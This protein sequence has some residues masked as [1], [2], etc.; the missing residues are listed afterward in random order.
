ML[1]YER[2]THH[3]ITVPPDM[4]IEDALRLMRSEKVRR[5]PVVDQ[6]TK[7]VIGIVTEKD[8]LY[9]SPSPVTS[10]SIHEIHYLL[11]KITVEQVM[12]KELVTVTEEETIEEAARRMVDHQVG[13]LPVMRGEAL[14][15]IITETDLFKVFIELF[16]ARAEGVRLTMLVPEKKGQ[17][18]VI[19]QAIAELGGNVVS[20]GTFLGED[21]TNRLVTIKVSDVGEEELVHKMEALGVRIVDARTCLLS[22]KC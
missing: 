3:P 15:G 2:M 19:T 7:K 8:L 21:L 4:P 20:L 22:Q 17:L 6:K 12:A 16:A 9:A 5:F 10:L 14:V 13:A 18:F 1:V 11:S